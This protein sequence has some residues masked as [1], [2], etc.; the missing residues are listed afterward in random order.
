MCRLYVYR[1]LMSLEGMFRYGSFGATVPREQGMFD[2]K[3]RIIGYLSDQN[4]FVWSEFFI[5][6]QVWT[7]YYHAALYVI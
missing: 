3:S 1:A 7:L 2:P 5:P 4:S 6:A